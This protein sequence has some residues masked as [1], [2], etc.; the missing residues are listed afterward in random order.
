MEYK[1]ILI[2]E[3]VAVSLLISVLLLFAGCRQKKSQPDYK[4]ID[5]FA[6]YINSNAEVKISYWDIYDINEDN[7][8]AN[9]W[10]LIDK[11]A[12]FGEVDS[13]RV[14]AN[15]F[16]NN[17]PEYFLNDYCICITVRNTYDKPGM[18]YAR[19]A[20]IERITIPALSEGG[21]PTYDSLCAVE[22]FV[23]EEDLDYLAGLDDIVSLRIHPFNLN[24]ETFMLECLS[25]VQSMN[26]LNDVYVADEWYDCFNDSDIECIVHSWLWTEQS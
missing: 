16:L 3:V 6:E 2:V 21:Y 7:K 11:Q 8:I 9:I 5:D 25:A 1:R 12:P 10:L 14:A 18:V 22:A 24:D 20:N 23:S 4:G 19:F 17:N 26:G 13:I 15:D